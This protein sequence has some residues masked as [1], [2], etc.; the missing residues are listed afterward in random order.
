MIKAIEAAGD[1]YISADA[2]SNPGKQATDVDS[3]AAQGASVLIILAQDASAIGP[4]VQKALDRGVPVVGYERLIANKDVLNVAFDNKEAGRMQARALFASKPQGNYVFINGPRNDPNANLLFSG[5]MEVLAAPIASGAI[6][7]VGEAWT[8]GWLPA[9]AKKNME[10]FLTASDN[11]IDAVVAADDGIAAG[12][13][14]S[15]T[16]QGLDGA[17]PV[18]GQGGDHAALNRVALGTQ[19]VSVWKDGR[20]LGKQAAE[21]ASQLADG[22]KPGEIE[23]ETESKIPGGITVKSVLLTP[24]AIT[25]NNL[26]VVL[27]AGWISREELCAGIASGEVAACN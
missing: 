16:T 26:D 21:I 1:K 9:N 8:A 25:R 27:D 4:A 18:S 23:D 14:A 19:T 10:Q 20:Q 12:V 24:V 15:L 2:Q 17:V 7:D 22:K 3:L 13:I 5:A 11:K 6:Q